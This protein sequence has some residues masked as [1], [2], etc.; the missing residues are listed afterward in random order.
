MLIGCN[1]GTQRPRRSRTPTAKPSVIGPPEPQSDSYSDSDSDSNSDSSALVESEN[2]AGFDC[3]NMSNAGE[4]ADWRNPALFS[5][6]QDAGG[7]EVLGDGGDS[8]CH[9]QTVQLYLAREAAL[10]Y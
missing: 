6:N 5:S 8:P 4:A 2:L 1:P 9:A 3:G 10:Y 7:P